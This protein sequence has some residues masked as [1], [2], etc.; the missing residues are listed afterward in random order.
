MNRQFGG[1][2]DENSLLNVDLDD[3]KDRKKLLQALAGPANEID[4]D[5]ADHQ[6]YANPELQI[7]YQAIKELFAELDGAE[8]QY[9]KAKKDVIDDTKKQT[10]VL[11]KNIKSIKQQ[12]SQVL[13]EN[14]E[15]GS[16]RQERKMDPIEKAT[17]LVN[18]LSADFDPLSMEGKTLAFADLLG[19]FNFD[20]LTNDKDY[21]TVNGLQVSYAFTDAYRADKPVVDNILAVMQLSPSI[22]PEQT[23]VLD[24]ILNSGI[25]QKEK[26]SQWMVAIKNDPTLLILFQNSVKATNIASADI[27]QWF[28]YGIDK[29]QEKPLTPEQQKELEGMLEAEFMKKEPKFGK[30]L[31]DKKA[32]FGSFF[33]GARGLGINE[34]LLFNMFKT[35]TFDSKLALTFGAFGNIDQVGSTPY[36]DVSLNNKIHVSK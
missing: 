16:K 11:E 29:A 20:Q 7:K 32:I 25:T 8:K 23:T 19:N 28:T 4:V 5:D 33:K 6:I 27:A 34:S 26:I 14:M 13:V 15:T 31:G 3:P 12:T 9:N 10:S 30:Y 17:R 21:G 1:K 22:T 36:I 2:E 24:T 35:K 18:T